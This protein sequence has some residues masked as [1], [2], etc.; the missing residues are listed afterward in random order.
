[1]TRQLGVS[2]AVLENVIFCHQEDSVW[3]LSEPAALKKKFDEIFSATRYMKALDQM[4]EVRKSQGVDMKVD[5]ERVTHLSANKKKAEEIASLLQKT[6]QKIEESNQGVQEILAT[7]KKL[8]EEIKDRKDLETKIDALSQKARERMQLKTLK[9]ESTDNLEREIEILPGSDWELRD[10][11][12]SLK[13]SIASESGDKGELEQR[14]RALELEAKSLNDQNQLKLV[15]RGK[16]TTLSE[17]HREDV[18]NRGSLVTEINTKYG[19]DRSTTRENLNNRR[20]GEFST[21][22]DSKL[23]ELETRARA[24]KIE[25]DRRTQKIQEDISRLQIEGSKYHG[26]KMHS[27]ETITKNTQ[28]LANLQ[29]QIEGMLASEIE[30]EDLQRRRQEAATELSALRQSLNVDEVTR[31]IAGLE[32][33]KRQEDARVASLGV[34]LKKLNSQAE[35]LTKISLKKTDLQKIDKEIQKM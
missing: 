1:M 26:E 33:Q 28:E 12:E 21:A 35:F 3:P 8:E 11:L 19:I 20:V 24:L 30:L 17:T 25:A 18:A 23:Q 9:K 27:N 31:R 16:L 2:K 15:E 22:L 32:E 5:R 29:R 34:T 4:K 10:R 14:K 7:I 13:R 6:E